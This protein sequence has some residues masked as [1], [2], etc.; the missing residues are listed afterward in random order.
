[1]LI[2]DKLC[3][4]KREW[5]NMLTHK[6]KNQ[7]SSYSTSASQGYSGE[8][9][10][11]ITSVNVVLKPGGDEVSVS[12]RKSS[13][14][15]NLYKSLNKAD[16]GDK[17]AKRIDETLNRVSYKIPTA[18]SLEQENKALA[19]MDSRLETLKGSLFQSDIEAVSWDWKQIGRDMKGAIGAY[20]GGIA[21]KNK[22]WWGDGP[23]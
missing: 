7:P 6:S 8:Q 19:E 22:R 16:G 12:E 23:V 17:I 2:S 1:M 20:Q 4:F 5:I 13:Y 10:H 3:V 18:Y 21:G 14:W 15:A 9:M 11:K